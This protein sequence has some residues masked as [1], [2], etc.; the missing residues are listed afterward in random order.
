M[1]PAPVIP[2]REQAPRPTWTISG[3]L[4]TPEGIRALARLCLS[5]ARKRLAAQAEAD[6]ADGADGDTDVSKEQH[7]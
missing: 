7:S 1:T 6:G 2:I 3:G 5:V 4:P